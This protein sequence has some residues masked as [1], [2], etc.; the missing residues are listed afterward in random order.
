MIGVAALRLDSRDPFLIEPSMLLVSRS[1]P[2]F[3]SDACMAFG[4][5]LQITVAEF[6]VVEVWREWPQD[7][8]GEWCC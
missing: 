5:V 7:G 4:I 6:W 1:L 8:R 2:S 3:F